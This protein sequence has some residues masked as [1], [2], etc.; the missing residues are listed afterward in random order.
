MLKRVWGSWR[1]EGAKP[2]Q[3]RVTTLVYYKNPKN[4]QVA[5]LFYLLAQKL[6]LHTINRPDSSL[7]SESLSNIQQ[8]GLMGWQDIN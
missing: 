7:R 1:G 3:S 4:S 8:V 2:V 6:F 5:E